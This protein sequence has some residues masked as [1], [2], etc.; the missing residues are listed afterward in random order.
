MRVHVSGVQTNHEALLSQF[1]V[2][3]A[4]KKRTENWKVCRVAHV[5]AEK[6][7]TKFIICSDPQ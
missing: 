5:P 2:V 1:N 3:T 6:Q 4:G 7:K